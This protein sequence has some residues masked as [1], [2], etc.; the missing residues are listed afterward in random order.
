MQDV[1]EINRKLCK[2]K[3]DLVS[4]GIPLFV[5]GRWRTFGMFQLI[6]Y[7]KKSHSFEIQLFDGNWYAADESD[8]MH[9]EYVN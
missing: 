7:R 6:P 5:G 4:K 2:I 3:P 9:H 1:Q 8:F